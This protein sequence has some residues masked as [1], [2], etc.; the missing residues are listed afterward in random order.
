[1][2]HEPAPILNF[3]ALPELS[4]LLTQRDFAQS[5]GLIYRPI[6]LFL[7]PPPLIPVNIFLTLVFILLHSVL[8]SAV[9][10][11]ERALAAGDDMGKGSE[12]MVVR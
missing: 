7:P 4:E 9:T 2:L 11:E 12:L 3:S 6:T 8:L 1:M 5:Y 10:V